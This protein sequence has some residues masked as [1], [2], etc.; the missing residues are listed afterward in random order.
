MLS[1]WAGNLIICSQ[2][3]K[4]SIFEIKIKMRQLEPKVQVKMCTKISQIW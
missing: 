1:K 4:D 2:S 3:F